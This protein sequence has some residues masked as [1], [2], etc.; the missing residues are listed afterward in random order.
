MYTLVAL[1]VYACC[2]VF[3]LSY[4]LSNFKPRCLCPPLPLFFHLYDQVI[5]LHLGHEGGGG[6]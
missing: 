5:P 1:F 3:K 4:L 2:I 6:V